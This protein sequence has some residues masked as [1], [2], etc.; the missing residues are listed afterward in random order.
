MASS[1]ECLLRAEAKRG[2][3][4]GEDEVWCVWGDD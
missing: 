3:R 1:L 4:N 2:A